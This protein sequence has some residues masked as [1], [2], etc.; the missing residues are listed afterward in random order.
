MSNYQKREQELLGRLCPPA[1]KSISEM[2]QQME[3]QYRN[4]LDCHLAQLRSTYLSNLPSTSSSRSTVVTT[5]SSPTTTTT[6]SITD[7][8]MVPSATVGTGQ[9]ES[10]STVDYQTTAVAATLE[11]D[12]DVEVNGTDDDVEVIH[13]HEQQE[14]LAYF[15]NKVVAR[16]Q[17]ANSHNGQVHDDIVIIT[18]DD[19]VHHTQEEGVVDNEP[20]IICTSTVEE[21]TLAQ[22][23]SCHT[24]DHTEETTTVVSEGDPLDDTV[25]EDLTKEGSGTQVRVLSIIHPSS[26]PSQDDATDEQQKNDG[27]LPPSKR[28]RTEA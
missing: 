26:T 28:L 23:V 14:Q 4:L 3:E 5:T 10:N 8:P 22:T 27:E 9:T 7:S 17:A 20:L 11:Q 2:V 1:E 21:A 24:N 19:S 16:L 6:S 13:Q 25:S 18:S 15:A 12:Q